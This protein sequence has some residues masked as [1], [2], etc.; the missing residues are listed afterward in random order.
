LTV[1]TLEATLIT[2]YARA[3]VIKAPLLSFVRKVRIGQESPSHANEIGTP[4]LKNSVGE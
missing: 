2:G 4:L 1:K 3:N